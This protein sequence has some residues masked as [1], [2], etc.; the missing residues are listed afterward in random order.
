VESLE[1]KK[2]KARR[3]EAGK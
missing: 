2:I 3:E 1:I